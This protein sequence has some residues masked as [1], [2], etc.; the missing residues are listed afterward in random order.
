[1]RIG[2]IAPFGVRMPPELK[3]WLKQRAERNRRSA[4]SE[5]L[6]LMEQARMAEKENAQ[7][8]ATGQALVMQ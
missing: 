1:M 2:E 3:D 8:A 6:A 5:I 7:P 4:N